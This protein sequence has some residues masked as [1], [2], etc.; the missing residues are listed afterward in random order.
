[1]NKAFVREPDVPAEPRCPKCRLIGRAV[2]RETVAAH[3]CAEA[4]QGLA[5]AGWFC[6]NPKCPISYYDAYGQSLPV[7]VLRRSIYPKDPDAP[8]CSCFGLTADAVIADA[9]AGNPAGVRA[10]IARSRLPD[11]QCARRAP[12]GQCCVAAV[13]RLYARHAT[14]DER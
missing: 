11:A 6:C 10:L 3:V 5:G 4:L 1:M 13:Q 12:D 14:H 2:G 8:I 7:D 9:R